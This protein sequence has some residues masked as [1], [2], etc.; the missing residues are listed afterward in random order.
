MVPH[1]RSGPVRQVAGDQVQR[2]LRDPGQERNQFDAFQ[3]AVARSAQHDPNKE[4][5]A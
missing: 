1:L 4:T 5:S 2:P 3:E